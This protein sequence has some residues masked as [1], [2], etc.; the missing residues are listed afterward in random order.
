[1]IGIGMRFVGDADRTAPIEAT[2]VAASAEGMDREDLR[3]LSVL[4]TWVDVHSA[5]V[6]VRRLLRALTDQSARV[7]LFWSAIA[8]WQKADPRWARVEG[9]HCGERVD[10][11]E[12][13]EFLLRRDGEDRR[14]AGGPMR[15]PSKTL[16][17]GRSDVSAPQYLARHHRGYRRRL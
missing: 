17:N 11:L 15:V 3:V 2:L 6:D 8:H 1:M 14:F 7:Q 5:C 10:L 13:A 16:R 4:T 12:G 9:I